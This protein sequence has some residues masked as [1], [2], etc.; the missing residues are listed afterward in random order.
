MLK[1]ISEVS[2]G[3][4]YAASDTAAI[5]RFAEQP[6]KTTVRRSEIP[7]FDHPLLLGLII[8]A[9]CAE[10]YLRKRYQLL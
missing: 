6:V 10:W 2:G 9:L 1:R 3:H 4:F 7:L 8:L 5:L